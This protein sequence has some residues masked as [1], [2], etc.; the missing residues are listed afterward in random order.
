MSLLGLTVKLGLAAV[1]VSMALS[2]E[3]FSCKP[4]VVPGLVYICLNTAAASE[5]GLRTFPSLYS[6]AI[7]KIFPVVALL[8]APSFS[9][10]KSEHR[11]EPL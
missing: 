8:S 4:S 10:E 11:T 3:D 1:H 2:I 7:L 6:L 9:L 5:V